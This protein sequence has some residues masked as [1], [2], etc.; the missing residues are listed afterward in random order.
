MTTDPVTMDLLTPWR[1]AV[2]AFFAVLALMAVTSIL[3][4][5]TDRDGD[6]D[7]P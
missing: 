5:G 1:L 4:W 2:L 6:R 3:T 7:G